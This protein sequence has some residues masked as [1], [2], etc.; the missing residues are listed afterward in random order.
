MSV[1]LTIVCPPS[2]KVT[3]SDAPSSPE[4]KELARH[5][6]N[7]S[8][9]TKPVTCSSSVFIEQS[10][11][12]ELNGVEGEEVTLMDWGNVIVAP[13]AKESDGSGIKAMSGRLNLGGDVKKTKKLTWISADGTTLAR[14]TLR[15]FDHLITKKKI[16]EEDNF[17]DCLNEKT[18]D[19]VH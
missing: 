9:G 7:A 6:K 2:V 19:E 17:E 8:L 18:I 11:A 3:I 1:V 14:A 13:F 4:T 10:D 12:R 5:K 16:E 15:D